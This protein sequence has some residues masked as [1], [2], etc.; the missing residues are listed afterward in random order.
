MI[1]FTIIAAIEIIQQCRPLAALWNKN[2]RGATCNN[3]MAVGVSFGV[4]GI[5]FDFL[6]LL[7]PIY[8]VMQLQM[9]LGKRLGLIMMFAAGSS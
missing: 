3:G 6:I 5:V 8:P 9:E 1:L 4:L 2:I 7:L